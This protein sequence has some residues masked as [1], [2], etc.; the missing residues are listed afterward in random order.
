MGENRRD[1]NC[2]RQMFFIS[3]SNNSLPYC[4]C[5][6]LTI[7]IANKNTFLAKSNFSIKNVSRVEN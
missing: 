5:L 1:L 2:P 6:F 4:D 3:I 7:L